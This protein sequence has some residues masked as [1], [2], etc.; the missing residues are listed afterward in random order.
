MRLLRMAGALAAA[1]LMVGYTCTGGTVTWQNT[2]SDWGTP[3]NWGGTLPDDVAAFPGVT[4]KVNPDLNGGTFVITNLSIDN[5]AA[6][7]YYID[8]TGGGKLILKGADG[9]TV[10]GGDVTYSYGEIG[11]GLPSS[12]SLQTWNLGN[13]DFRQHADISGTGTISHAVGNDFLKFIHPSASFRGDYVSTN[14]C[15]NNE[16]GSMAWLL[17]T[18][19]TTTL[20]FGRSA[21]GSE[22]GRF[23]MGSD[24]THYERYHRMP[25]FHA[26]AISTSADA[27][28]FPVSIG[29]DFTVKD[30]GAQ[31]S[32][33]E[34][35]TNT[36]T[37]NAE[38]FFSGQLDLAG[39]LSIRDD[40]VDMFWNDPDWGYGKWRSYGGDEYGFFSGGVVITQA[41]AA[42]A[43]VAYYP[44]GNRYG[45]LL[46]T[47][48]DGSG[49]F[50]N[51]L[52]LSVY[53]GN[54]DIIVHGTNTHQYGTV[55][56]SPGQ[57]TANAYRVVTEPNATLGTGPVKVLPGGKLKLTATGA[58]AAGQTVEVQSSAVALANLSVSYDD[59]TLA[60]LV[61]ADSSGIFSFA[62]TSGPNIEALLSAAGSG[63]GNG[64]MYLG[65]CGDSATFAGASLKPGSDGVY[66]LCG[67]ANDGYFST[68]LTLSGSPLAGAYD[69]QVGST[70]QGGQGR[71][72]LTAANAFAGDLTVSSPNSFPLTTRLDVYGQASPA[73]PLGST[74]GAVELQGAQLYVYQ[75]SSVTSAIAKAVTTFTSD[76]WIYID[77]NDRYTAY[78]TTGFTRSN[79]GGLTLYF[80]RD[81][82]QGNERIVSTTGPDPA[83]V[84]GICAPYYMTYNNSAYNFATYDSSSDA[85]GELG[86]GCRT[87]YE[88][89]LPVPGDGTNVVSLSAA[90]AFDSGSSIYAL[91]LNQSLTG[92]GVITNTGGGLLVT[93]AD[94]TCDPDIH[95]TSEAVIYADQRLTMNGKVTAEDGLT[96]AGDE[97]VFLQSA[98]NDITGLITV[99][100]G[101]LRAYWDADND[102]PAGLGNISNDIY[103]N[104]GQL[105]PYNDTS[106]STLSSNRTVTLGPLGGI[107]LDSG[108]SNGKTYLNCKITGEGALVLQAFN[109]VYD[110]R[111]VRIQ[112]AE[113]DYSGG[114]V[115]SATAVFQVMPEGKLG[116]GP[117]LLPTTDRREL[118]LYGNENL[119]SPVSAYCPMQIAY[120]NFVYWP[121]NAP[122][123]GSLSGTGMMVLGDRSPN[124]ALDSTLTVG[125]DNGSSTW[126][127]VIS[128][129][130]SASRQ[131][132]GSVVKDGTGTWTVYGR[133]EYR[134]ATTI[135]NGTLC[136]MGSVEGDM[137]VG[138]D[139]T[140][141]GLGSIGGDLD[142][143]GTLEILL[144]GDSDYDYMVV[145][146]NV[147]LS[148]ATVTVTLADGY[149][150]DLN[151]EWNI[152][153]PGGSVGGTS[154]SVTDGYI[155][156]EE[157]GEIVLRNPPKGT[158]MSVR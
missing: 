17:V 63:I 43:M 137:N 138:P 64:A 128:E 110:G 24:K 58:V 25:T 75:N 40:S 80:R 55:I 77:A 14:R 117:V 15:I 120:G 151:M 131:A 27:T 70:V 126:Y 153:V 35:R 32:L 74:A 78:Q 114:T 136:L 133:Q 65:A 8:A 139:G 146:G 123:M 33:G 132:E 73:S 53:S 79:H 72:R 158:V 98:V 52:V 23:I 147:D 49:M 93:G 29:N 6:G 45:R 140:L 135:T 141:C 94:R 90:P 34:G 66:R 145:G 51:P 21:D 142:V 42:R 20:S 96:K 47:I 30:H 148:G 54:R 95:F 10:S 116:S 113:N 156:Y 28:D 39:P 106:Y 69:V 155:I 60:S 112:G 18:N 86:F 125:K 121:T 5:G 92:S 87:A 149:A 108:K 7:D 1:L 12:T 105:A 19:Q 157:G 122:V 59:V 130:W 48:S 16:H 115:F 104:G 91:R 13:T 111:A 71:V 61:D 99:N 56:A 129:S 31:F 44:R 57:T 67:G 38:L 26:Y 154:V 62:G 100:Y 150:P 101:K 36:V 134:G 118:W 83:M 41:V 88:T 4:P 89:A 76:N 107:L 124:P 22:A 152:I 3:A 85:D 143:N 68:Y 11:L 97:E 9:I 103:L 119:V 50:R 46:G 144:R 81:K 82:A 127:G 84:N 109:E 102:T 2:G 37:A